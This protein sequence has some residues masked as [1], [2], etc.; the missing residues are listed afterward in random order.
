MCANCVDI[1]WPHSTLKPGSVDWVLGA[2]GRSCTN[3]CQQRRQ[4]CSESG[5]TSLNTGNVWKH[6]ET[7]LGKACSSRQSSC[8]SGSNCESWGAPYIHENHV[9][10]PECQFGTSPRVAPCGKV[11]TPRLRLTPLVHPIPLHTHTIL[12]P[13]STTATLAPCVPPFASPCM[14]PLPQ[15]LDVPIL[16]TS[17]RCR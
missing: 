13:H 16:A 1:L 5:L 11:H 4:Q 10:N 12:H 8:Q 9:S 17:C 15:L 14:C 6:F 2:N 7:A 3:V